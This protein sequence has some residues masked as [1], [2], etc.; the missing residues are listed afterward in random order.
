MI[1]AIKLPLPSC[2]IALG[3]LSLSCVAPMQAAAPS[4]DH[5]F[6]AWLYGDPE[7]PARAEAA[8]ET[9]AAHADELDAIHPV[10]WRVGS[11]TSIVNHPQGSDRPYPGFHDARVIAHTTAGGARTKLLPMIGASTSPDDVH[12]H[13]MINDP[14][15]RAAHVQAVVALAVDHGYDGIDL[16]Y[17]H[18]DREH[19][20]EAMAPGETSET[21]RRA[22]S[23]FVT[24]VARAMHAAGKTISLAVPADTGDG[25]A[26]DYDALSAA[27]DQVHIMG[28]DYHYD[29]GPHVG[30]VAPLGWIQDVVSYVG[31]LDGGR[32]RGRFLLGVPNYGIVGKEEDGSGVTVTVCDTS[33]SCAARVGERYAT[34]TDHMATCSVAGHHV[35]EPGRTPNT[36]LPSGETVFFEDLGSLEERVEAAQRG[37]LGGITYWS[38]GG[39]PEAPGPG[40]PRTFFQMVRAHFP[41]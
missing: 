21:E 3:A 39:E 23:A 10:W 36:L 20:G 32:R 7:D 4:G 2:A 12:V 24:D 34:T 11:P 5:H 29:S 41:R 16:D 14:A 37:G 28:Y 31:S 9:F 40:G 13:R 18:L 1:L 25:S 30:P 17:E 38:M 15:L 6:C 8:Y 27:A 19:L 35:V 26:Y 22:F 33:A